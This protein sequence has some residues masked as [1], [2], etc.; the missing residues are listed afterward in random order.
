[1][2][3]EGRQNHLRVSKFIYLFLYKNIVFT[4]GQ[5]ILGFFCNWSAQTLYDDWYITLFNVIF[6]AFTISYLGA[7][8][9]DVR[10]REYI[11]TDQLERKMKYTDKVKNELGEIEADDDESV[12]DFKPVRV[13]RPV[14]QNIQHF[15]YMT[16]KGLFFNT[17]MFLYEILGALGQGTVITIA[18]ILSYKY[19]NIDKDGHDSDFW[20]VSVVVYSVLIV[21]TNLMSII[22]SSH[23][24]WLLI[25]AIFVTSIGPFIFWMVV[26]DSWTFLNTQSIF[27]VRFILT[28][29]HFYQCVI[30]STFFISF[31]EIYKFFLKYYMNPTMT[32][33]FHLLAKKKLIHEEDFWHENVIQMVKKKSASERELKYKQKNKKG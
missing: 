5:F 32:E 23:I 30:L 3:I 19:F 28:K 33:Y 2:L 7:M 27:S 18:A 21:V 29:W 6:T 15:Y 12:L 1:V 4:T 25:F 31:Y 8:D 20:C 16:Q 17:S 10:F 26:Y 14:K 11:T 22:R 9:Q 13:I 24:T